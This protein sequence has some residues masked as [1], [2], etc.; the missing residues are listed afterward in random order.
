MESLGTLEFESSKVR[1]F[2]KV[3]KFE[4]LRM[5]EELWSLKVDPHNYL[6]ETSDS[7][8]TKSKLYYQL[9]LWVVLR[10]ALETER[11]LS[12]EGKRLEH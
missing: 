2:E 7:G 9:C 4:E 5:F 12:H 8:H 1:R 6:L 10:R 11:E 3:R